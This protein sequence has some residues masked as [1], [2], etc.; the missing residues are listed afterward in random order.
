MN[1]LLSNSTLSLSISRERGTIV[2]IKSRLTRW[3]VLDGIQEGLS[4]RLLVPVSDEMRNNPVHGEKQAAPRITGGDNGKWVRME[5]DSVISE[6]AGMLPISIRAEIR[7]D[8]RQAVFSMSIENQSPYTVENVYWPYFGHVTRPGEAEWFRTFFSQFATSAE[9]DLWP[10]YQ[11][12]RGYCGSDY[13]VQFA[14]W[15][16]SSGNPMSPYMLLRSSDEGLYVGAAEDSVEFAAWHTELRPGWESSI[17]SHVPRASSIGGH[18]VDLRFSLVHF[19]YIQ[20]GESRTLVPV[21]VEAY[22]GDWQAGIDIH[23]ARFYRDFRLPAVPKWSAEPHSWVQVHINSPEDELRIKF[24]DLPVLGEEC[25]RF[26]VSAI[27]LVGWNEGGQDQG[28][29]SHTPDSRLGTE[30]ELKEAIRTIRA[31]GVKV[32]LFTKFT[33]ADR[34]TE[35]FRNELVKHAIKDP[36][37]DYQ[38]YRG[39]LYQTA[40]QLTD[41]NTRRLVPM[42]F[43]SEEYLRICEKEFQKV[44]DLEPDGILFDE[45]HHHSPALLCFDPSHGHRYGAPVYANDNL[46]IERFRKMVRSRNTEFLFAGEAVYDREMAVYDLSYHRSQNVNHVPLS[47]YAHPTAQ[48]MTAVT[49]FNDRNMVNQ[50]LM[51]RYIISYEAYNFKGKLTD[52]PDTV[53]YGTKMDAL[54]NELR[55]LLWD[56]EFRHVVGA[57]VTSDGKPH[58]PYSVFRNRRSS[59]ICVVVCNYDYVSPI[60]VEVFSDDRYALRRYRIVDGNGWQVA[61]GKIR[62]P[63]ESAAVV[64]E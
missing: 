41:I 3:D 28:N 47:R 38:V 8:D 34:A 39:Y 30:R 36:Y 40:T 59:Q 9:W 55:E 7:L 57:E 49:G 18:T 60:D 53:A 19:P 11:N 23:R 16:P 63:P 12:L 20:S 64:I 56:G 26:G 42:C 6:R 24:S 4:F 51:Y 29:P 21:A 54:R 1:I 5:W 15:S 22:A 44:L 27:Q 14:E 50:C 45:C 58:H 2:G 61:T 33:W 10:R 13:P 32:I 31:M 25:V 37:G 48:H 46:L 43:L 17:D 35:W 52:F 62:I